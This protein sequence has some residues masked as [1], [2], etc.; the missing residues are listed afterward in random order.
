MSRLLIV[1]PEAETD[2][3]EAAVWYESREHGLG[4]EVTSEIQA[5]IRRAFND[6][7]PFSVFAKAL[8]FVAF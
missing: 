6:L 7:R 1:R 2:I 5:A 8:S 4:L 3:T